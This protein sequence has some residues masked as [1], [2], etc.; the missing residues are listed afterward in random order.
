M[1]VDRLE[2]NDFRSY[3]TVSLDI[4]PGVSLFVGPNGNGKT[5]LVEA[6]EYIS[7]L[8]SHRVAT[9][10]PLV[11][12]GQQQAIVRAGVVAGLEDDRRLLLELE[13]NHGRANHARINRSA[14]RRVRDITGALRTVVFSPDDLAIVKGEP[15]DRRGFIDALV[16]TRWPRMAGVKAD[17]ERVIRQRNALLKSLGGRRRHLDE[18]TAGT[19]DVWDEQLIATGAELLEARLDTLSSLMGPVRDSYATIAPVKNVAEAH[20]K[21]S[22]P[23]LVDM[24]EAGGDQPGESHSGATPSTPQLAAL[25]HAGLQARRGEEVAR[26]VS[27]VGPHR[28]D[29]TLI[30]GGLPAKGYAS[31]GESWSLALALRLGSLRLLRSEA[32]E[33]VLILDDV[34]A[35]LDVV[36]RNRLAEVVGGAE[37]A[38]ITAAVDSD[39]PSSLS[40]RRF[41]VTM[42]EE[43]DGKR[44]SSVDPP[45]S[46]EAVDQDVDNDQQ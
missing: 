19:L 23:G 26:G 24:L 28:D 27:L 10:A 7:T 46:T 25:L 33:P 31:H 36:R 18:A 15:S 6:V 4:G 3:Q 29:I 5:N 2:L 12:A 16:A 8:S 11:R 43:P 30:I 37:Q 17:Y 20:Y 1:Y 42:V 40:T 41:A 9:E 45:V 44:L 21:S 14:L 39:V 22:L 34:F 38:L 13:L 35:E 32:V